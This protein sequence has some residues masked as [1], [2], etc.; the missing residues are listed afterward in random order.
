MNPLPLKVT[1]ACFLQPKPYHLSIKI[2]IAFIIIL[3]T[4]RRANKHTKVQGLLVNLGSNL[5]RLKKLALRPC[6][7]GFQLLLGYSDAKT[8]LKHKCL[9]HPPAAVSLGADAQQQQSY[10]TPLKSAESR[11]LK[12]AKTSQFSVFYTIWVPISS[13]FLSSGIQPLNGTF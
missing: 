2:K 4:P 6:F 12:P 13:P 1:V 10:T 9:S 8:V 5:D 11:S 7:T 3:R